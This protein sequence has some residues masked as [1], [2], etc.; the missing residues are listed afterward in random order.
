MNMGHHS[1]M[2]MLRINACDLDVILIDA[3]IFLIID[4]QAVHLSFGKCF[5]KDVLRKKSLP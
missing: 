2:R 5:R 4:F 1:V 3:G